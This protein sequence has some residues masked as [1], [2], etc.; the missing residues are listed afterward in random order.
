VKKGTK[1]STKAA[2]APAEA[3]SASAAPKKSAKAA[4][5][6]KRAATTKTSRTAAKSTA[7]KAAAKKA[8]PKT[9][10]KGTTAKAAKAQAE[11]TTIEILDPKDQ[12]RVDLAKLLAGSG[13]SEVI[14]ARANE[15]G[16]MFV[17]Y[18]IDGYE[19]AITFEA[20]RLVEGSIQKAQKESKGLRGRYNRIKN[21]ESF[22]VEELKERNFPLYWN[23]AWLRQELARL[24]SYSEIARQHGFKNPT[25]I[26]SYAKRKFGISV[27]RDYEPIRLAVIED[28]ETGEYT[29]LELA[30][31]HNVG[32]ATVYRWLAERKPA[33]TQRRGR[34]AK[35]PEEREIE[36]LQEQVKAAN[37]AREKLLKAVNAA[38]SA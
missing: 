20:P 2:P 26:A 25:T 9:T 27:Q 22:S 37:K 15:D 38:T 16:T 13:K 14:A 29:Q 1:K 36:R 7:R 6:T 32:I 34:K 8:T 12:F 30:E 17:R 3:K 24:G 18:D 11:E 23:E 19:L 4:S 35:T 28:F 10:A 33:L 21:P 31:K 5:S